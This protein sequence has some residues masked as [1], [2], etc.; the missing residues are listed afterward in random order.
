MFLDEIG[1]MSLSLQA[2]LLRAIETGEI[3]RLG[4]TKP[5]RVDVRIIAATHCDL[6]QAIEN[7]TFR[8]D[9]YYRLNA[10]SLSLPPL[11]ERR[12]DIRMLAEYFLERHCDTYRQPM[13]KI[14]P[15][16][17]A[18][19]QKYPWPGNIRELENA[20]IHAVILADGETILPGHLPKEILMFQKLRRNSPK[21]IHNPAN[22]QAVTVP[23]GT[24]LKGME[25]VFIRATLA[26][27]NGNRTKTASLLGISIRTLQNRL[28]DYGAS[29]R[30]SSA[31]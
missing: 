17:L 14:L 5:I 26:S 10:V 30:V 18:R 28:K 25:E 27:Q 2:K 24:N 21:E 4:G 6:A 13:R 8:R 22:P 20:L 3:E 31:S 29:E 19:L 9:L 7:G 23:L 1:D 12:E 15:E 11:R 16:T